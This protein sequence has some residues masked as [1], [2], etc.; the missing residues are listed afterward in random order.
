MSRCRSCSRPGRPT[1]VRCTALEPQ[2]Q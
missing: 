2:G 1:P